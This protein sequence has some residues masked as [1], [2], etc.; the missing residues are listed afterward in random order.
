M[1]PQDGLW[2]EM[3]KDLIPGEDFKAWRGSQSL[4]SSHSPIQVNQLECLRI[5]NLVQEL[6]AFG[7]GCSRL[8]KFIQ[9]RANFI[10]PGGAKGGLDHLEGLGVLHEAVLGEVTPAAGAGATGGDSLQTAHTIVQLRELVT[11]SPYYNNVDPPE[12]QFRHDL[13]KAKL[14]GFLDDPKT[15]FVTLGDSTP[16]RVGTVVGGAA[17]LAIVAGY[18]VFRLQD[19]LPLN[20][21]GH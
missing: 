3:S 14:F 19:V 1:Q 8:L 11:S 18:V 5:K 10:C 9:E 16:G 13:M 21:G 4:S 15:V 7:G 6:L 2:R 20:Q 17:F 12:L